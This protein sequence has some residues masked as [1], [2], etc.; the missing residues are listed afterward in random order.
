LATELAVSNSSFE[1][2]L[3]QPERWLTDRQRRWL[4][5]RSLF[6]RSVHALLYHVNWLAVRLLFRFSVEGREHLP[7]NGPCL[8]T[9]NHSSPLDA[10]LL[11][12]ALPLALL[13]QAYWAGK[14]TTV[15]KTWLRR[16]LSWYSRIVPIADDVT[17]L[18]PAVMILTQGDMLLWFPE[19]ERALDGELHAFKPGAMQ[20][21]TKCNVPVVPVFIQG[22]HAACPDAKAVPRLWTRVVVR[23]GPPETAGR[24]G[25]PPKATNEAIRRA[26]DSL[27]QRVIELRDQSIERRDQS[28]S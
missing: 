1:D 24:L 25:L 2:V 11:G 26:T 15:L 4:R 17:A 6:A 19:G 14:E 18:A 21:L 28:S 3:V 16:I 10:Q 20:L 12:A 9:P 13:R 23:I 7:L 27:R 8:I 22:A 5:P